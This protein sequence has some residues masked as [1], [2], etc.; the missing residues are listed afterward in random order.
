MFT[1]HSSRLSS[2][3]LCCTFCPRAPGQPGMPGCP[4]DPTGPRSPFKQQCEE[5]F[6]LYSSLAPVV[7]CISLYFG[8]C[9]CL[10]FIAQ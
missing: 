7:S 4:L 9:P 6:L 1:N 8:L 5:T 2:I 3:E 10:H